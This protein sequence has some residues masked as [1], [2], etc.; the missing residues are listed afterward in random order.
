MKK[1]KLIWMAVIAALVLVPTMAWAQAKP[2]STARATEPSFFVE[3]Y[4]G[5]GSGWNSANLLNNTTVVSP[6]NLL[7]GF[8]A[9]IPGDLG[10]YFQGGLKIGYWFTPQGTY[11]ASWYKDWMK[12]FGFFT[13]FSYH[14]LSYTNQTGK[15]AT[16]SALFPL[17]FGTNTGLLQMDTTGSVA[18][19]AFMF[20]ARYGFMQDSEVP[21]GRLQPYVAV[22]PA[23]FFS[24]QK[25][26]GQVQLANGF[27]T[28]L[29]SLQTQ[30]KDSTNIGLAAE[31]GLRYFFN[32][33]VSV[34]ASVKYRYFTPSY[35]FSSSNTIAFFGLP[36]THSVVAKPTFNLI[37]GQLG[38]AYHF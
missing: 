9:S 23:V 24:N 18:T 33:A 25:V 2:V 15:W 10:A 6:F 17:I 37:S 20:A 3:V 34:E 8:S 16:T 26:N 35:H 19:W 7:G 29:L 32:K 4:G 5:G 36:G 31:G 38:F 21:F 11:A 30:N 14:K 1:G 27:N 13:D 12:Y 22:G 28:N